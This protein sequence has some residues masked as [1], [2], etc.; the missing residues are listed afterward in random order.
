MVTMKLMMAILLAVVC[1]YAILKGKLMG[2]GTVAIMCLGYYYMARFC[3]LGQT[4]ID[5]VGAV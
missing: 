5:K 1:P 3:H 2:G 4:F